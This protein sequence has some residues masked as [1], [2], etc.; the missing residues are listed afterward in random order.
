MVKK[1]LHLLLRATIG[2]IIVGVV[3]NAE[4]I[5]DG[6]YRY[7]IGDQV[8]KIIGEGGTG[9]GFHVKAPSGKT[10]ILTNEHVCQVADK[11]EKVIVENEKSSI[12]RRIIAKY[13]YHDLCL[14]EGLPGYESGLD[15]AKNL[16]I[17]EDI[18]L[19]GHPSGR[20]LTLSKGEFI[21]SRVIS[22]P[23]LEIRSEEECQ[24]K[25]GDWFSFLG[26]FNVCLVSSMA[27][28]ITNPSYPGNSG[29]PVINKWG[30]V[31]GVL[32]AGNRDQLNDNY[33]VPLNEVKNFLKDY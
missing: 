22:L 30:N 20:P 23:K 13:Q 8:V 11:H 24:K 14:I 10:Y 3:F 32:F 21:F 2:L 18:I 29:S 27:N 12:P 26:F 7:S 33:M 17:G 9:S 25:S 19:I 1:L 16:E 15:I 28:G 5:K 4:H 31:V 6:Y